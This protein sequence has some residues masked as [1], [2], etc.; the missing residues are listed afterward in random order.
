[1][2]GA[3]LR[4]T[5]TA[6]NFLLDLGHGLFLHFEIDIDSSFLLHDISFRQLEFLVFE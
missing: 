6:R 5:V 2:I 1:M 4:S 3:F